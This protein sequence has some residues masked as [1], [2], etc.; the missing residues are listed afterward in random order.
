MGKPFEL[1]RST[2]AQAGVSAGEYFVKDGLDYKGQAQYAYTV[3]G[4]GASFDVKIDPGKLLGLTAAA[5]AKVSLKVGTELLVFA[6]VGP[7]KIAYR[8]P[9]P[10]N[11]LQLEDRSATLGQPIVLGSM[12]GT[13]W[14]GQAGASFEA[15]VSFSAHAGVSRSGAS[16][17]AASSAGGDDDA[18]D[19]SA[20]AEFIGASFEASASFKAEA[21]YTFANAALEDVRPRL[22]GVRTEGADKAALKADA[23]E[24][25]AS[26]TTK[27]VLKTDAV[28]FMNQNKAIF[29]EQT[30]TRFLGLSN[31]P[32]AELVDSLLAGIKKIDPK[33]ANASSLKARAENWAGRLAPYCGGFEQK[34]LC[35]LILS[36][37]KPEASAGFSA[38]MDAK[39]GV[40]PLANAGISLDIKGP[41]VAGVGKTSSSRFQT[42][43]QLPDEQ[44]LMFTQEAKLCYWQVDVTGLS[45]EAKA[46]ASVIDPK[47]TAASVKTAI[48]TP[49][50]PTNKTEAPKPELKRAE[51]AKSGI[52]IDQKKAWNSLTYTSVCAYWTRPASDAQLS[53]GSAVSALA[54]SGIS[55]GRSTILANLKKLLTA[56]WDPVLEEFTGS[57]TGMKLYFMLA[58]ALHLPVKSLAE[59]IWSPEVK[60]L[61]QDLSTQDAALEQAIKGAAPQQAEYLRKTFLAGEL[62]LLIEVSFRLPAVT[63]KVQK[64]KDGSVKLDDKFFDNAVS[65]FNKTPATMLP[66]MI[67]AVRIRV[68]MRDLK[69]TTG[70]FRLGF[71]LLGQELGISYDTIERAGAEGIVD[72]ATYWFAADKRSGGVAAYEA[73]VPKVLLFDQ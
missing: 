22:Y 25:F 3:N 47:A 32:V 67:E 69:E 6:V 65:A 64:K 17:A 38:K 12:Q 20:R 34:G 51:L 8:L 21:S 71:K 60:S 52:V 15:G 44:L 11:A 42:F 39:V 14:E 26:G 53:D 54:G 35:I 63:L 7:Q 41:A 57:K 70:G 66:G 19:P 46:E 48:Q 28:E 72:L 2:A 31:R 5:G 29:G 10:K 68:R 18:E 40:G 55:L 24:V 45:A 37:H 59:A 16:A 13:F 23:T 33:A 50:D 58:E 62:P 49:K 56:G 30:K 9:S 61:I 27:D 36:S 73:A 1:M 43:W 4:K